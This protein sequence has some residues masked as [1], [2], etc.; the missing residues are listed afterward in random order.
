LQAGRADVVR[1]EI[2]SMVS[3]CKPSLNTVHLT[4]LIRVET[5]TRR[6]RWRFRGRRL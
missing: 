6:V 1:R 4:I 5:S 3:G 2:A